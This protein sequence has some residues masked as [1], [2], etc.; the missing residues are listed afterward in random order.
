MG[1]LLPLTGGLSVFGMDMEKAIQ[2]LDEQVNGS[3]GIRGSNLT[4]HVVDSQTDPVAARNGA[5]TL[6]QQKGVQAIVGG[7][8]SSE[9]LAAA[10]VTEAAGVVLISPTATVA[11]IST[12]D[13]NDSLWRTTASD[14]LQGKAAALLSYNNLSYRRIGIL[15]ANNAY[16]NA[17]ATSFLENFTVLGG[18]IPILVYYTPNQ[19]DYSADLT[20]L[21]STNPEAVY[22]VAYPYEGTIILNNWWSNHA[23][24]PTHWILTDGMED[25]TTLDQLRSA[26]MNTTGFIGLAPTRSST[27]TGMDAYE[28]FRAAFAAR[29]GSDPVILSENAYDS[30]FVLALAMHASGSTDP[31]VFRT[32]IRYVANP[33]GLRILPGQ[34]A[35]AS[36][37]LDAGQDID[38]WGAANRVDFDGFGDTGTAYGVWSVNAVGTIEMTDVLDEPLFWTPAGEGSLPIRVQIDS[39]ATGAFLRGLTTI[40]GKAYASRGLVAVQVQMDHGIWQ[41][42]SGTSNWTFTLDTRALADGS[43]RIAARSFDGATYSTEA[44]ADITADNTAPEISIL[45]PRPSGYVAA[46]FFSPSWSSADPVSG[47]ARTEVRLDNR[48]TVHLPGDAAGMTFTNVPEGDHTLIVRA[49]DGAGNWG[50]ASVAFT[51]DGQPPNTSIAIDGTQG[52]ASWFVS[53]VR[54]S[55]AAEDSGAGVGTIFIQVGVGPWQSYAA[56]LVLSHDGIYDVSYYADDW[57][58]NTGTRTT[59]RIPID[60][61]DPQLTIVSMAALL[62]TSDV[63]IAWTGSDATSGIARYEMSVDGGPFESV[64]VDMTKRLMLPEGD[65]EIRVR[66][67]DYAG[68]STT[69]SVHFRIDTNVFSFSGPYGGAPTIALPTLIAAIALVLLWT[70]HRRH[71]GK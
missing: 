33:P 6:I 30:A 21:F 27:A 68:L 20:I 19:A 66:A 28:R 15:A 2:L 43:H 71:R 31:S 70:R 1:A 14:R 62:P 24:W 46:S 44:S 11:A 12:S 10:P 64:G 25:Q 17:L 65:H 7:V 53:E 63:T 41:N 60:R 8:S 13:S 67:V 3:G 18:T 50:D 4:V 69:E 51:A 22:L 59:V 37:A 48:D 56:P 16:G 45:T 26:G 9:A 55:L 47:V 35:Q 36:A 32:A 40:A 61:T 29:F 42:A 38:Y 39:P 52:G 34:W 54:I 58:G 57:V 5:T 23:A 49:I